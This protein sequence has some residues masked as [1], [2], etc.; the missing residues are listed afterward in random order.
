[1]DP[2]FRAHLAANLVTM[3]GI[4]RR[5]GVARATPSIWKRK[6]EAAGHPWPEPVWTG[7][8]DGNVNQA[9]LYWWPDIVVFLRRFNSPGKPGRPRTDPASVIDRWAAARRSAG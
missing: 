6:L 8:G 1:M 2:H 9:A 7:Q 4:S 3:A 5:Y